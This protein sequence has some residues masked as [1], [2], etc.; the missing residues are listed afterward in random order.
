M[1]T[2][3]SRGSLICISMVLETIWRMRTAK[4][5]ARAG[6]A[7]GPP[8][9]RASRRRSG[10][11][12]PG[13]TPSVRGVGR[14]GSFYC[15]RWGATGSFYWRAVG[16]GGLSRGPQ[17]ESDTSCRCVDSSVTSGR[18]AS[19]RSQASRTSVTCPAPPA[20]VAT[21]TCAR[22]CRSWSPTSAAAT[23]KR[24][25][26]SATIGRTTA[27]LPLSEW[28]SPSSRSAVSV[29]VN[30]LTASLS[31]SCG[32]LA[33]SRPELARGGGRGGPSSGARLLAHLE[34]LDHV[35]DLDVVERPQADAALVTLADL[36]RVVLEP[37]EGLHRQVVG[38]HGTVA[39]EPCL[40]VAHDG[41]AADQRTG[42]VADL[43]HPEDLADLRRAEL[44][45]LELRL[46]HPLER[47][48]DLVDGLVDDR[49]VPDVHALAV[50]QL[51][52]LA[53]GPD[54]EAQDDDVVGQREVDVALG[55]ATDAA[56]DDPQRAVR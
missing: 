23:A 52:G 30:T 27:R 51:G 25:R 49:V 46:E 15:E 56:V 14:T 18:S 5:R 3:P 20:T 31:C 53:L 32:P 1:V 19:N 34:G 41:A 45:L 7:I 26:S 21:P 10:G 50:G 44:D 16:E 24:R 43:R 33:G 38:D 13:P 4:R 55:D 12:V 9:V 11:P 47:G 29:P 6:S 35:V 37:A 36:G 40:R 48:L 17:S 39:D 42:D 28:T 2:M 8:E 22:R 54:V